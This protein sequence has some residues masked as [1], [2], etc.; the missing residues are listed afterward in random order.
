[1]LMQNYTNRVILMNKTCTNIVHKL[2]NNHNTSHDTFSLLHK[3]ITNVQDNYYDK[4]DKT[5]LDEQKYRKVFCFH[6]LC[7]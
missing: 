2:Q 1:M 3:K 7:L 5:N 4:W 6:F